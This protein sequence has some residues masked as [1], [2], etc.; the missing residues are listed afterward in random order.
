MSKTHEFYIEDGD[1]K[2]L[3]TLEGWNI[4][5]SRNKGNRFKNKITITVG[6]SLSLRKYTHCSCANI[7]MCI[8]C[9]EQAE[10]GAE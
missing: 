5:V 9:K 10:Q 3:E 7:G 4:Y 2:A 1:L 6:N 8:Y